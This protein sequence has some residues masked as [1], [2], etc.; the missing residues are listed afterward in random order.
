MFQAEYI[1]DMHNNYLVLNGIKDSISAYG[2]KMLLNNT[3]PGFLKVELRCIDQLDLFYY[4]V[5]SLK[6]LAVVYENKAI[7]YDE[8]KN[9]ISNILYT[10]E[11]GGEFL[12][13]EN[14]F[15][16]EPEYIFINTDSQAISLCHL[17][18]HQVNIREQISKLMEYLM[19]KVNYQDEKA[20]LLI[21]AMYKVSR[22][23]D[24][25]FERLLLELNNK[26]IDNT[27]QKGTNKLGDSKYSKDSNVMN[28]LEYGRNQEALS[29][30]KD[31]KKGVYKNNEKDNP[32]LNYCSTDNKTNEKSSNNIRNSKLKNK[33]S[34]SGKV[35]SKK[36]PSNKYAQNESLRT[37]KDKIKNFIDGNI[38]KKSV[39]KR[40]TKPSSTKKSSMQKKTRS[41][42]Y[43]YSRKATGV[44]P[45]EIENECEIS[46]FGYKTYLLA[47]LSI[48]SEVAL[49]ILAIQ[50][51]LLHNSF[52]TKIDMVKL[53]CSL[54]IIGMLELLVL[55]R[56]FD[57]KNQIT[58]M[59]LNIEYIDPTVETDNFRFERDRSRNYGIEEEDIKLNETLEMAPLKETTSDE[60]TLLWTN[61]DCEMNQTV[62]LAEFHTQKQYYLE[63]CNTM[64]DIAKEENIIINEFPFIIGKSKKDVNYRIEDKSVSR[65][66]VKFTYDGGA[67]FITDLYST[68][69]TYVNSS[70]LTENEAY[71][72]S[73]NDEITISNI[74]YLWKEK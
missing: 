54:V 19:N 42:N 31:K 51:K 39:Q 7:N 29:R 74:K 10:I 65:K 61:E 25:T 20:V 59:E 58:R 49:V 28:M 57:K 55:T 40:S 35:N 24:C 21:Y 26:F 53:L 48:T 70:R 30:T 3:I 12:L 50:M 8:M 36:N 44:I 5:T 69:G 46:Y 15:I 32:K 4:D 72:L 64:T 68:N 17:V 27:E 37:S 45:E 18:G 71:P 14:D 22:E 56:L 62:I 66:H 1:R 47:A 73:V 34:D 38:L 67:V 33:E 13:S 60:T 23:V 43:D 52:G 9:L 63:P 11:H 6:T 41:E 16:V 2:V